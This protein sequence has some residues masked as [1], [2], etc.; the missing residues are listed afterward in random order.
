MP[1]IP[2]K[3]GLLTKKVWS[4]KGERRPPPT[5]RWTR[6]RVQRLRCKR[7]RWSAEGVARSRCRCTAEAS[8]SRSRQSEAADPEDRSSLERTALPS[9]LS[10]WR[11][12]AAKRRR[13][14]RPAEERRRRP[15]GDWRW[16]SP[17]ANSPLRCLE[18]RTWLHP[19]ILHDRMH[20]RCRHIVSTPIFA[21]VQASLWNV[22]TKTIFLL[23]I[24]LWQQG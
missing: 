21:V 24:A 11:R 1:F 19:T 16:S 6:R 12:R 10:E 23:P 9:W 3:E 5:P 8:C 15:P 20:T 13:G 14:H 2:E 22:F 17:E 18:Q 4:R 7:T